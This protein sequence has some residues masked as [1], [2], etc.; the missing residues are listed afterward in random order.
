VTSHLHLDL[1]TR[2]VVDLRAT[3][4]YVYAEHPTTDVWCAAFAVDDGPIDVWLP[5]Q[6]VPSAIVEHQGD[7]VAHNAEFERGLLRGVL[8]PRYGWPVI[9][10]ERWHCTAA[11][12]A[13]MALP[14]S[15]DGA[16]QVVGL[17]HQKDMRGRQLMLQLCRPRD[18]AADGTITWWD[19]PEKVAALIEYCRNDVRVERALMAKLRPLPPIERQLFLLDAKINA[20]G[21]HVDMRAV[22]ASAKIVKAETANL[23]RQLFVLTDGL[24]SKV[25]QVERLSK[26]LD[27]QGVQTQSLDKEALDELLARDDLTPKVRRVVEIRNEGNKSSTTK[28]K[29]FYERTNKDSRARGTMLFCG[30]HT[31]RWSGMGVQP[32]N[33]VRGSGLTKDVLAALEDICRGDERWMIEF[34]HGA[35]LTVVSDCLR[36]HITAAPGHDL[37]SADFKNIEGRVNAWMAGETWKL[38]AFRAFDAGTGPD[39]YLLAAGKING[40][41]PE[42]YN[43]KSPERQHGKVSELAC[44]YQGG[45]GAFQK[46]AKN[47]R[48]YI[49]DKL[50]QSVVVGWRDSNPKIV[51][52]WWDMD[53]AAKNAVRYPGQVF[54]CCG[55]KLAFAVK[56]PFLWMRLPSGGLLAY[57]RPIL[58]E[59]VREVPVLDDDGKQVVDDE[60]H[61]V[62]KTLR[63]IGVSYWGV[64]SYTKKW[65]K[66]HAYGGL[67]CENAVQAIARDIMASAMLRVEAAGYPI[68]LT[69]HDEIV[70]EVPKTFGDLKEYRALMSVIEP[71]FEG[72]PVTASGWRGFR[73]RK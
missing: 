1:E 67:W 4:V 5:G 43:D 8:T 14:R 3:G 27:L 22:V 25:S 16:A 51:Q 71:W 12:G 20:R 38:D 6:P 50:A 15:L 72:C 19:A 68:V 40:V 32:H 62:T 31:R 66:H 23:G 45:V 2:S 55:D 42:T 11:M 34:M 7:F 44:G 29:A 18:I 47:Y 41:P 28:L 70:A 58:E 10:D 46:M 63:R 69:V 35:P 24:V 39:L 33:M 21:F 9:A 17:P 60:G 54:R 73:Y 53:E 59:H 30:A 36:S 61:L 52:S 13:E 48:V 65:D 49:E 26:W 37:M 57:A 56:G 64:N